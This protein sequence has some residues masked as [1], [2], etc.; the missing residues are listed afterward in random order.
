M[1]SRAREPRAG[2]RGRP[3]PV[4]IAKGLK[5]RSRA[6]ADLAE[7]VRFPSVSTQPER[8]GDVRRCAEWLRDRLARAGLDRAAIH[9]TPG[10]PIV[11]A[12]WRRVPGR[13]TVLLY[14]HFDVQP[15]DPLAEWRSPPFRPAVREGR[16]Y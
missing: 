3:A 8:A 13:P 1:T 15:A 6:V 7:F 9:S 11:T 10:H 5:R 14:G 2:S 4:P 12:E 16:L